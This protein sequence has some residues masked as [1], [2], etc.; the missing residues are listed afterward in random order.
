MIHFFIPSET[1]PSFETWVFDCSFQLATDIDLSNHPSCFSVLFAQFVGAYQNPLVGID[2][3]LPGF[4]V[5][6][7][8]RHKNKEKL[9]VRSRKWENT[10]PWTIIW[11]IGR[12]RARMRSSYFRFLQLPCP[13]TQLN[14]LFLSNK[15]FALFQSSHIS[16]ILCRLVGVV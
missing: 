12:E 4:W 13:D 8:G 3:C 14:Y 2:F 9:R 10:R 7:I 5:A 15:Y 6:V 11:E 1:L 16:T